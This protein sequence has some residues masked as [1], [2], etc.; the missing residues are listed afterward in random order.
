MEQFRCNQMVLEY[1]KLGILSLCY[2]TVVIYNTYLCHQPTLVI[3]PWH[4]PEGYGS[5][6]VCLLS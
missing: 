3:N 6:F 1:K 4:M 2:Y 5:H